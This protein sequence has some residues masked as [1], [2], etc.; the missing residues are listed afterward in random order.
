M[1]QPITER[2]IPLMIGEI[3]GRVKAPDAGY[4]LRVLSANAFLRQESGRKDNVYFWKHRKDLTS[5]DLYQF[6][7][8]HLNWLQGSEKYARSVRDGLRFTQ[9]RLERLSTSSE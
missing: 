3:F 2:C 1:V 7:G 5:A 6:D 9:T 4:N 8:F